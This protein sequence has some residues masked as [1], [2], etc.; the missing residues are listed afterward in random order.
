MRR[1][2]HI[3]PCILLLGLLFLPP[4]YGQKM[5]EAEVTELMNK[6]FALYQ[7]RNFREAL[8]GFREVAGQTILQRS[9]D[10]HRVH[11][12]GQTMAVS[13]LYLLSLFKEGYDLADEVLQENLSE[14]ERANLLKLYVSCGYGLVLQ[15][16]R[17]E[18]GRFSEARDLIDRILPFADDEMRGRILPYRAMSWYFEGSV[19]QKSLHFEEAVSCLEKARSEYHE[20]GDTVNELKVLL[21]IGS[22]KKNLYDRP[23]ALQ[24]YRSAEAMAEKDLDKFLILKEQYGLYEADEDDEMRWLTMHRIDSLGARSRDMSLRFEYNDFMGEL[25]EGQR[26]YVM[27]ERWYHQND[28]L[29]PLLSAPSLTHRHYVHLR[30]HYTKTGQWDEALHYARL[31]QKEIQGITAPSSPQYYLPYLSMSGIYSRLGDS[32]NCF[33]N[34]DTLFRAIPLSDEPR[35]LLLYYQTRGGAFSDFGNYERALADYRKADSLLA[36]QYDE[37]DADRITLL[38]LMG[39]MECRLGNYEEGERLYR[40]YANR[41]LKNNGEKSR[42]YID[43]LGYLANAEAFAGHLESAC[44]DYTDAMRRLKVQMREKWP[45]LSSVEREAYWA[46]SSTWFL[47]MTPF[48]LKSE[49]FQTP[50]TQACYDGLVLTKS[51]LLESEQ[52]IF[53]LIRHHGNGQDLEL[54]SLIQAL[55]DRI[56]VWERDGKANADSILQASA[57]L[58]R[59]ESDLAGQCRAYGD[60]TAFMEMDYTRIK[61]ELGENDILFDFT[62]FISE[63]RGRV[64]AAYIVDKGQQ[65]PLL[66]QLFPEK[67]IDELQVRQPYQY[68]SGLYAERLCSLLWEPLKDYVEEGATVYYVP[69]Q[70]L[71]QVALE[72]LP[73]GDGTLLGDHFRFV[74]LSSARELVRYN[75]RMTVS[76]RSKAVL[77]GGLQY[78]LDG[79]E[80]ARE[81]RKHDVS[82]LLVYRSGG[83]PARGD[84]LFI[85]LP[86]SLKE[87]ETIAKKLKTARLSVLPYSGKAGTEESFLSMSGKAPQV[88]HLATH[89]FYYTPDS[90]Q[91]VDYLRGFTDAMSLSGLVLAGGNAA[92]LGLDLPEGVLG[93]ILTAADIAR[94]DLSGLDMVVLSAC[95]SGK[96]EA[97]PEGL[98][99]LQRAFKKA[100][101]RTMVMS[102]WAESDVVGPDFMSAFYQNLT[103]DSKWDK[104]KAFDDAKVYIRR[105]YPDSPS[106]WAGFIMLD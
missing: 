69:T 36:A 47:E 55:H 98:Y 3:L 37:D 8:T 101:V 24:A 100:G 103:G 43:A 95:H 59:M 26:R 56:R 27:A 13:C 79:N 91:E 45:Y 97:T 64:Y 33:R 2:L 40:Q 14:K 106:F 73:M 92:W 29:L 34:I 1:L 63:S 88:L 20:I 105:K 44:L 96:G 89:G 102:L 81:A 16:I 93:G 57:R 15:Y 94:M 61:E 104:R 83:D 58:H 42:E 75:A 85:D 99:G 66:K 86:G 28:S 53:D 60:A 54:Y 80:M 52:S 7:E 5:S 18:S 21:N 31:A 12:M 30:S 11:V 71:F 49:A 35:E 72:S 68:Y 65:Y 6:S 62:D 78:S 70:M 32:L 67:E 77:Y 38:A 74:R 17:T 46:Q 41:I 39:G 82:R 76:A 19:L 22:S 90:A 51:F 10:E 50:F 25:C 4:A 48:A 87:I 23:G 84:S 9:A